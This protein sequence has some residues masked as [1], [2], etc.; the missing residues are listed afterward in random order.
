[1]SRVNGL[2]NR[3]VAA[4]AKLAAAVHGTQI[5]ERP[6]PVHVCLRIGDP[7]GVASLPLVHSR[8]IERR[9]ERQLHTW[10]VVAHPE[11]LEH[12]LVHARLPR[13]PS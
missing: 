7:P 4:F 5:K 8:D 3:C 6:H 10:E 12:L 9:R 2:G 13:P 11:R 1:M